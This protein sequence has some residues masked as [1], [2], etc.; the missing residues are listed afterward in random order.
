MHWKCTFE[1]KINFEED[2]KKPH[3]VVWLLSLSILLNLFNEMHSK[4]LFEY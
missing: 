1:Q 2:E 3:E 4:S